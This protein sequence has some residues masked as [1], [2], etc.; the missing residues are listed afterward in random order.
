MDQSKI[1]SFWRAV[2]DIGNALRVRLDA[3][4]SASKA[5]E[6]FEAVCEIEEMMRSAVEDIEPLLSADLDLDS[7]LDGQLTIVITCNDNS[8]G[9]EAVQRLVAS[10][11]AVLPCFQ[12][13]AFRPP[14]SKEKLCEPGFLSVDGTDI[15]VEQVRFKPLPSHATLGAFD[16]VCF[17][18]P[19]SKAEM[20]PDK[21]PGA[22]AA[23]MVLTR[24][25]GELRFMTR[26][27]RLKIAVVEPAP[28][29]AVCA[30]DLLEI[31][32]HAPTQ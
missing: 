16:I 29:E 30:W 19:S 28:D 2:V 26:I 20:D 11:P 6:V 21:V 15:Q 17:V 12:V 4:P 31:I 8:A 10:A 27:T 7:S 14:M 5:N 22:F 1:A 32:D 25:I 3:P 18:P 23:Y 13:R 24:G 9:I